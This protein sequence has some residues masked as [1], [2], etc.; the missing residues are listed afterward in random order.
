MKKIAIFLAL[1]IC[2]LLTTGQNTGAPNA[3]LRGRT[4]VGRLPI[5][6]FSEKQSGTV[7]VDIWVD[8]YGN[9]VKAQAGAEGTTTTSRELWHSAHNAAMR[10][11]FNQKADAPALQQGTIT[12]IFTYDRIQGKADFADDSTIDER[13]DEN[14]L[15]FLGI[16]VDG[17]R[18]RV[19]AQLN[20]K[21][22]DGSVWSEY[23]E[24]Q[25]N[26]D[27]VKVFVHTY[28]EKVDRIIVEFDKIPEMDLRE[29]YNHLLVLLQGNEKYKPLEEYC[30]IP[31]DDE[32]Y[33][34]DQKYKACFDYSASDSTGDTI[35]EVWLSILNRSGYH[36][37][38]YYD[39]LKN[40]PNGEDL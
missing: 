19:I 1:I 4:V 27:P 25:F 12:Y 33:Y 34:L 24:G 31:T 38:L 17:S 3:H 14:A 8:N 2:P 28:H 7:V 10:A 32:L 39:N 40:R 36:V 16:P 11:H 22:Y 18:E 5:P 23:L 15:K 21:G 37:S 9:V 35:G 13:I 29:Q 30:L 20:E 6:S 26:G